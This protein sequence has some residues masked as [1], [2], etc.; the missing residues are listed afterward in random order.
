MIWTS[1]VHTEL[2]GMWKIVNKENDRDYCL[3]LPEKKKKCYF[4]LNFIGKVE[5]SE[6]RTEKERNRTCIYW[7]LTMF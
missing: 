3:Q 2:S 6:N 1:K 5:P 7:A 4:G